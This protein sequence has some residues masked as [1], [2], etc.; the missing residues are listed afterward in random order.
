MPK[1]TMSKNQ[2]DEKIIKKAR[3]NK[4]EDVCMT[5]GEAAGAA[6]GAYGTAV[7][8]QFYD[9]LRLGLKYPQLGLREAIGPLVVAGS[10]L[11]TLG[12]VAGGMLGR[13]VGFVVGQGVNTACDIGEALQKRGFFAQQSPTT[14]ESCSVEHGAPEMREA[15][16]A[17]F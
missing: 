11:L 5:V 9:I 8:F 7:Y 12:G 17:G 4:I 13:G 15:F 1:K 6:A 10:C 16:P 3:Q 14:K 2:D